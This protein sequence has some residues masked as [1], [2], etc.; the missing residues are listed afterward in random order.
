MRPSIEK[1]KALAEGATRSL[2]RARMPRSLPY[3]VP[4]RR[5]SSIPSPALLPAPP[6]SVETST[7]SLDEVRKKLVDAL[8]MLMH[9]QAASATIPARPSSPALIVKE[10]VI[11]NMKR[12]ELVSFVTPLTKREGWNIRTGDLQALYEQDPHAFWILEVDGIPMASLSAISYE[13]KLAFLGLYLVHPDYRRKGYGKQLWDA[14]VP[15]IDPPIGLNGVLAQVPNYEREGFS[16]YKHVMRAAVNIR[17]SFEEPDP[18]EEISSASISSIDGA[19]SL[20][21]VLEYDSSVFPYDRK[22]FLSALI[23]MPGTTALMARKDGKIVGYGIMRKCEETGYK[24]APLY[25]DDTP[26]QLALLKAFK[27]CAPPKADVYLN[28]PEE[29]L[30]IIKGGSSRLFSTALMYKGKPP[31]ILEIHE[32]RVLSTAS[33][34]ASPI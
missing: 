1:L 22:I 30:P 34:E 7:V 28:A 23:N 6:V 5:D 21:G 18:L 8:S 31:E 9:M 13:R 17:T 25:A 2:H 32:S 27:R 4:I 33:I 20:A 11:R 14:V 10:K 26:T 16:T 29:R 12:G 19:R 15:R 3:Y 24:I